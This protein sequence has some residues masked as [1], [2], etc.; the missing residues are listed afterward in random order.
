MKKILLAAAVAFYSATV[1]LA[2]N[3]WTMKV[4]MKSGELKEIPCN[5]I[6]DVTFANGESAS[7][8]ADVKVT[9]TY[10]L[11]YGAVTTQAGLYTLHLCDGTTSD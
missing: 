8:Y 4:L 5:D 10:N 9:H 7:Y 6:Q 3:S 1:S 11:Y 2:Q